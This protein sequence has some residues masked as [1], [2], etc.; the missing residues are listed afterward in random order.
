MLNQYVLFDIRIRS[1]GLDRYI[2]EVHS[3]L[4]G[5]AS[6]DFASPT[7][8][9][10]YRQ[11]AERLQQLEI[12]EDEL[13]ELGRMLFQSIFQDKIKDTYARAQGRLQDQQGQR[14]RFNIDP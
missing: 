10:A 9:P 5:D 2:V 13:S 12:S 7:A 1:A 14:L 3:E 6:S 11:L 8:D 4:G